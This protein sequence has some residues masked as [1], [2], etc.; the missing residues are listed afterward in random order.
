MNNMRTKILSLLVLLLTAA[1]GAWA[2]ET[3]LV[4]INSTGAN[5]SFTSGSKTFDDMVTVTFSNRVENDGDESGWYS[6]SSASLLTVAG[7]N[8]YTITSCKFYTDQGIAKTGYTVEGESPS[9]YLSAIQVY[10][11]DSKSVSIG[12]FGVTKI[13]VYGAA[14]APEPAI[15][16]TTN[17][18]SEGATFTEASFAMPA[19]D[20][21]VDY[22]L[23]RDMSVQMQAQ[24]GD[25]ATKEPRYRVKKDGNN[26]FIPADM[27]QQQVAALFSVNDLVENTT[28]DPKNYF[29]SIY[30]VN[31]QGET[32]GD[33]MTFLNFTFAP[34]RYCVT[35][36]AMLGSPT[37]EGTTA[38][39]NT[40]E[41]FQGYEVEI[42]A[43]SFATYYKDEA[44]TIDESTAEDAALYTISEV[45]ATE[46]VL[47]DEIEAAPKNTPLL[48]FNSSNKAKTIMLIPTNE[49]NLA[50]TVAPEFKGT[51]TAK[52]FSEADMEAANFYVL[53]D[54]NAFVWV[55]GAGQIAANKCWLQI[56]KTAPNNTRAIVFD[57]D[58]TA[59]SDISGE[60]GLSGDWYDISGRKVSNSQ[61]PKT[62]GLYINGGRKVV[63][64]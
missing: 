43:Q 25:D 21:D 39:S 51:L 18:A 31:E 37:Y 26:K 30:A 29:V 4:T 47:S 22:E 57:N 3:P 12:G 56:E 11:D 9:V 34:G 17:A 42:A 35:A 13:E 24:V 60:S 62:K 40:F 15:E 49:P 38:L 45:T 48:I 28:L 36:S 6:L 46:A 61:Q 10:I 52:S 7:I 55:K 20:V 41:L 63:I 1:T 50:L 19:F 27:T 8:G 14:A 32:T 59:I 23:V 33:P 16:V 44:L 5:S 58:A 64:K 2:Q 53:T 54:A